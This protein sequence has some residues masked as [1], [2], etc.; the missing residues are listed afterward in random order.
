[1]APTEFATL[2]LRRDRSDNIKHIYTT[3]VL[4]KKRFSDGQQRDL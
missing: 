4:A 2:F 1:M 3:L